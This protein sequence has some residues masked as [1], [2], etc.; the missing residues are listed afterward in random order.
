MGIEGRV[1]EL[2]SLRDQKREDLANTPEIETFDEFEKQENDAIRKMR[3]NAIEMVDRELVDLIKDSD[4]ADCLVIKTK[5]EGGTEVKKVNMPATIAK[6][7]ENVEPPE[8]PTR[9]WDY[10]PSLVSS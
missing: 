6:L 3:Q 4:Y 10:N 9:R 7:L 1:Y 8:T 2:I 5:V